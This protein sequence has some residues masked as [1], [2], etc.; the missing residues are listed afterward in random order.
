MFDNIGGKIKTLA[1]IICWIG[2]VASVLIGFVFVFIGS[3]NGNAITTIIG[4]V[5]AGLGAFG[6]WISSFIIIGFGE[7]IECVSNIEN[8]ICN[9]N[10]TKTENVVDEEPQRQKYISQMGSQYTGTCNIC[11]Q[12]DIIVRDCVVSNGTSKEKKTLC[13]KCISENYT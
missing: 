8:V 7:L 10:I 5:I 13:A 1:Q 9:G 12:E 11:N 6:S 3:N 2:I 4:L